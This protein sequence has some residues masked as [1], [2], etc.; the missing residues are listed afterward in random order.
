[1]TSVHGA[2][3][4]QFVVELVPT[5]GLCGSAESTLEFR[6][7]E[8]GFVRCRGCGL[9]RLSP[10]P[11]AA[12]LE[13]LYGEGFLASAVD[14]VTVENELRDPTFAYRRQ[15]L[16]QHTDRRSIVEI[17]CGDGNFLAF[18]ERVGWAVTGT[19]LT[20]QSVDLVRRKHGIAVHEGAFTDLGFPDAA[21]DSIGMYHV[22]EH[23][24]DPLPVI[25]EVGRTLKRG[26]IFHVQIPHVEG[27]E[28]SIAGKYFWALA[29]P[30]HAYLYGRGTL[31][32]LLANGG[33][34]VLS[35][36]TY[37]PWHSPAC[38]A[39]TIRAVAAAALVRKQP[40]A[41]AWNDGSA[42]FDDLARPS[43]APELGTF[44]ALAERGLAIAANA[45]SRAEALIGRGNV[46]DVVARRE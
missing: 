42:V 35:V 15:V 37:D 11:E 22:L 29:T 19:E 8:F 6:V 26:G 30:R 16:E 3:D 14:R 41:R 20:T 39:N 2:D 25:T 45:L 4:P 38:T 9:L 40:R 1:M 32:R 43:G 7:D 12:A 24:Y 36:R 33:L 31:S 34:R 28:G 17:G 21:F 46:L 10:R 18:L 23:V 27:I 13:T 44:R 5:C